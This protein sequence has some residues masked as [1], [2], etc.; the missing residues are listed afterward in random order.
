MVAP[1]RAEGKEKESNSDSRLD[2]RQGAPETPA[3]GEPFVPFG[4]SFASDSVNRERPGLEHNRVTKG[5]GVRETGSTVCYREQRASGRE[6]KRFRF[7][8]R[9]TVNVAETSIV[10]TKS[11]WSTV[12]GSGHWCRPVCLSCLRHSGKYGGNRF[13]LSIGAG[14]SQLAAAAGVKT[15]TGVVKLKKINPNNNVQPKQKREPES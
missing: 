8:Q 6:W 15:K 13:G 9:V 4:L 10:A 11:E 14:F 1:L 5:A 7:C 3:L 2:N 12:L